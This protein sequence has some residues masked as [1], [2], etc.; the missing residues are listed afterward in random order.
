MLADIVQSYC[1]QE[2][3]NLA[4]YYTWNISNNA[5]NFARA[6]GLAIAEGNSL[7]RNL[8]LRAFYHQL[9][10]NG[11]ENQ[12]I[13]VIRSYIR[14]W[15]GIRA[16]GD[17]NIERYAHGIG[18]N[19]IDINVIHNVASYSKA[20]AV[21][22][23]QQYAIF[24]ARVGASLN[25]LLLLNNNAEMTFPSTQSRNGTIRIFQGMLRLRTPHGAPSYGYNEYLGLLHQVKQRLQDNN[26][27]IQSIEAIEM[28]LFARAES[29]CGEAMNAG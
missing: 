26:V 16:L 6:N 7:E 18:A 20:L 21:I 28:L 23:P 3:P 29:L 10:H 24:D 22:D 8:S 19:G 14:D 25:S 9:Y 1:E 2:L 13:A 11:D 17:D 15:G 12:K 27:N 4:N 5:L